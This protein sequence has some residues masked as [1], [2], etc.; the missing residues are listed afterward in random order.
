MSGIIETRFCDLGDSSG[1][2]GTFD[3]GARKSPRDGNG[4]DTKEGA[5]EP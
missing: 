3:R 1:S 5:N 2:W 4:R